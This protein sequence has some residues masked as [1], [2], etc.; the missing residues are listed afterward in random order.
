METAHGVCKALDRTVRSDIDDFEEGLARGRKAVAA[1]DVDAVLA[2]YE[3]VAST[4]RGDLLPGDLYDDWFDSIRSHYRSA[5]IDA[6]Q[7]AA[8]FMLSEGDG[9]N[10][11]VFAR[12]AIQADQLREDLYQ[13]QMRCQILACQRSS[14]I[15]TYFVMRSPALRGAG[16][17]SVS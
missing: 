13:M 4:Y 5:Y 14:A 8:T 15:D 11:L 6:M 7:R 1:H 17:G 16:S 2:A 3:Q 10:A 12:R 9:L